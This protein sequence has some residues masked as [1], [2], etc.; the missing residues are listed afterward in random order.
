MELETI[1]LRTE[2]AVSKKGRIIRKNRKLYAMETDRA[3]GSR[4]TGDILAFAGSLPP[5]QIPLINVIH[6]L[7]AT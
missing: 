6:L 5:Y 2:I 7:S 3:N 4:R 1:H